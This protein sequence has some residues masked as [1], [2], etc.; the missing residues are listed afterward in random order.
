[1]EGFGLRGVKSLNRGEDIICIVIVTMYYVFS[2]P[3]FTHRCFIRMYCAP[4]GV[5]WTAGLVVSAGLPLVVSAGAVEE[6][7]IISG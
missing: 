2:S 5:H 3:L 4:R 1:M 6:T 7:T